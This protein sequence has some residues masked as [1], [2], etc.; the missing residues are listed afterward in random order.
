M[1]TYYK[2]FIS[3]Q[4]LFEIVFCLVLLA[5]TMYANSP[6]IENWAKGTSLHIPKCT[7]GKHVC[8]CN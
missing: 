4:E 7:P 1:F 5:W 2:F 8:S 3:T 6:D